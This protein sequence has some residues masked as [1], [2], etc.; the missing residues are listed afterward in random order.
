MLIETQ[1]LK[2]SCNKILNAI[3]TS[4]SSNLTDLVE[5]K[6]ED[7]KLYLNVTNTEYY[8]SAIFPINTDEK[9]HATVNA[10]KFLKLIP[11]LTTEAVEIT[12]KDNHVAIK[13]NGK[14]KIPVIFSGDEMM[15]LPKIGINNKTC[16][17]VIDS[18]VLKS[19]SYYNVKELQ[20]GVIINPDIQKL[21]YVD[22]KG[23]VT[24]TT[25]ACVNNFTLEK[26]IKILLNNKIVKLFKL[27]DTETVGFALGH[28]A[29]SDEIIQTKIQL[30]NS[31]IELTAILN[32]DN[33]LM[34]AI[35]VDKIRGRAEANYEHTVNISKNDLLQAI[36]RLYIFTGDDKSKAKP[37]VFEFDPTT[38]DLIIWDDNR[39]NSEI[40]KFTGISGSDKT[41]IILDLKDLKLTLDTCNE[42]YISLSFSNNG[43][44]VVIKRLNIYNVLPLC[45]L[46]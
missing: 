25:G 39:E 31:N 18:E 10:D 45:D 11:Q 3:D 42:Q 23:A 36:N 33:S 13:A 43:Q 28:D 27:F 35:P 15:S 21:H 37:A 19:I 32:C 1:L 40:I 2:E 16:E 34:R 14:Y 26:P 7:N 30:R 20:K 17:M 5:L 29:L 6:T 9:F 41:E 12:F 4:G 22:E 38:M 24:F 46:N 44:A 8:V